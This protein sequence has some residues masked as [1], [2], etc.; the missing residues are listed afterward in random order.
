MGERVA[1]QAAAAAVV[2]KMARV[3]QVQVWVHCMAAVGFRVTAAVA[4]VAGMGPFA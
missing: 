2:A 1:V 3:T 4:L